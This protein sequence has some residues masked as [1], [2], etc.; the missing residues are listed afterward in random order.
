MTMGSGMVVEQDLVQL[1]NKINSGDFFQS[2][3]L[4]SAMTRAR[5]K[6]RPIHITG[7]VSDGGV[8]SHVNHLLALIKMCEQQKVKP[9]L[10]MITDG[11]DTSPRCA[12]VDS[13]GH[14]SLLCDGS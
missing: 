4:I 3:A 11:R 8:H 13:H 2:K 9:L 6:N 12:R 1:N 14:W 5:E 7:L 10:H